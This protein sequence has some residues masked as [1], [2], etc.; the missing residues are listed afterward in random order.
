MLC[1][2]KAGAARSWVQGSQ[3]KKR[4]AARDFVGAAGEANAFSR[5][6]Y[7]LPGQG[8]YDEVRKKLQRDAEFARTAQAYM[9]EFEQLLKRA[10]SG[11]RP[12][13]E[14][15][16]YLLSDRGRVYTMLAHASG[17]LN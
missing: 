3:N 7:T 9:A 6:I 15:R 10:A 12:V 5:R 17:R 11:P 2:A 8:T 13:E 1:T 16:D 4:P 14:S